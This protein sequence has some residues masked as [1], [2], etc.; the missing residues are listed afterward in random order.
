[1]FTCK[2]DVSGADGPRNWTFDKNAIEK[3]LVLGKV[4]SLVPRFLGVIKNI[5]Q[6]EML[7]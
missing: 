3:K 1:M 6:P 5:R 7:A 4:W 2:K